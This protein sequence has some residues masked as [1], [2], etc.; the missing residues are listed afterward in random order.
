MR[1]RKVKK[2]DVQNKNYFF[3]EKYKFL[4]HLTFIKLFTIRIKSNLLF[5]FT[6]LSTRITFNEVV[7]KKINVIET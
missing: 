2:N 4:E 3:I 1:R 7:K 5:I 6:I